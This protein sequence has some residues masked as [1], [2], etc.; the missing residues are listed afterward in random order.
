LLP[1]GE[2]GFHGGNGPDLV[3]AQAQVGKGFGLQFAFG[4]FAAA[5]EQVQQALRRMD[6]RQGPR[7][8]GRLAHVAEPSAA[9][10]RQLLHVGAAIGGID[11]RQLKVA[12]L[13]VGPGPGLARQP[14]GRLML[15]RLDEA[16]GVAFGLRDLSGHVDLLPLGLDHRQRDEAGKQHVVGGLLALRGPFRDRQVLAML[17]AGAAAVTG[18]HGVGV[19]AGLDQLQVDELPRGRL[20]DLHLA[21]GLARSFDE[22]A[23]G[24]GAFLVL[25]R[26]ELGVELR[27]Q[28]GGAL[29]GLFGQLLI[30]RAFLLRLL[31]HGA[32]LGGLGLQQA[33]H[34]GLH[35]LFGL[36]VMQLRLQLLNLLLQAGQL[37]ARV[38]RHD[39]GARLERGIAAET[40][41]EPDGKLPRHL[42]RFH[43]L[44]VADA[45]GGF[46]GGQ[47]AGAAQQLEKLPD[48]RIHAQPHVHGAQQLGLR[49]L[50]RVHA[51]A[52]GDVLC[53]RLSQQPKLDG[54]TGGV[55]REHPF[56]RGTQIGQ[57][58]RM[59]RKKPE[60]A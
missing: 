39:E 59:L 1:L 48:L 54:A 7:S 6:T 20:V 3:V 36:G 21:G 15:G 35:G 26:S 52:R 53:D 22:L 49:G 5:F 33:S 31:G 30:D 58:R 28:A 18:P 55:K 16:A 42:Q 19:P 24:V 43:A 17:R 56:G 57:Q 41:M 9:E 34:L 2:C 46:A 50:R 44:A 10:F 12:A 51:D 60:V 8:V 29:A 23:Q 4:L 40:A 13:A 37:A 32:L 45:V 27:L 25:L 11:E 14:P 38:V 47:V